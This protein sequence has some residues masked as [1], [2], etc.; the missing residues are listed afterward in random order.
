MEKLI[1]NFISKYIS[2]TEEEEKEFIKINT[3]KSYKKGSFLLKEGEIS[4]KSYFILK[5]CIRIFY[6]TEGIEKTTEFYTELEGINP[7][8]AVD[9]KPSK[10]YIACVEDCIVSEGDP[11]MEAIM[12]EKFPKFEL[13]FR[14]LNE[15]LFVKQQINF[16]EFKTSSPEQRYLNLI[17]K[18]PDLVQRVPQHQLASYLGIKPQSLSRLR[19]RILEKERVLC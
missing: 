15:E 8:C 17:Q 16:D 11:K 14:K 9:K 6:L 12:F 1:F 2:L 4:N 5:G 3:F 13:L 19:A 7:H 18:R 10:Y